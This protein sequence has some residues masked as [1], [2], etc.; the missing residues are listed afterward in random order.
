MSYISLLNEG[1]AGSNSS[2]VVATVFL[3][4][5]RALTNYGVLTHR[6]DATFSGA[7]GITTNTLISTGNVSASQLQIA[8]QPLNG[9]MIKEG[10]TNKFYT[11]EKAQ[12]D[13][14]KRYHLLT[15]QKWI[16]HILQEYNRHFKR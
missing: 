15:A 3:T 11:S 6:V 1:Q 10:T 13:A 16:L 9:D 7:N 5:G 4:V 12:A 2:F 8:G 14:K